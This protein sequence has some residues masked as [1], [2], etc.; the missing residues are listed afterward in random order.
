MADKFKI[1]CL[2]QMDR[3]S[4]MLAEALPN[5]PS[6]LL[7]DFQYPMIELGVHLVSTTDVLGKLPG[8]DFVIVGHKHHYDM[9][10]DP[11][12]DAERDFY[13]KVLAGAKNI[14][15]YDYHDCWDI[16]SKLLET[17][18]VYFKRVW[19][20][21]SSVND[22]MTQGKVFPLD[23]GILKPYAD[24]VPVDYYRDRYIDVACMFTPGKQTKR[25]CLVTAVRNYPN[26]GDRCI[27]D[28]TNCGTK[29]DAHNAIFRR[30]P[31]ANGDMFE[32]EGN[33]SFSW[34][35]VYLQELHRAKVVLTA[36]S[37]AQ[38]G[39]SRTWEAHASGALVIRDISKIPSPY[40]FEE[41]KH[42]FY[43]D[44]SK[45]HEI[46]RAVRLADYYTLPEHE[47]ER[48]KIASAGYA[49]AMQYHTSKARIGYMMDIIEKK[50]KEKELSNL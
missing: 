9:Y 49:H 16:P 41:G 37:D 42:C 4:L 45:A 11:K 33:R 35:Y 36:F 12:G 48:A 21:S 1:G 46:D 19:P 34:W 30:A 39:D 44:A 8:Y 13:E 40:P 3:H 43:F 27:T 22:S 38:E 10:D 50:L 28:N 14:V 25:G 26:W 24:L 23:Y 7:A 2:V 32:N 5:H 31:F 18:L 29:Y 20:Y 47:E 6:V 15:I 17:C